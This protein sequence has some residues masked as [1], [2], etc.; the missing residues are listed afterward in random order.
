MTIEYWIRG[1]LSL[2]DTEYHRIE[3]TGIILKSSIKMESLFVLG[4]GGIILYNTLFTSGGQTKPGD[5]VKEGTAPPPPRIN[6]SNPS[7]WTGSPYDITYLPYETF[8]GPGNE[9]RVAYILPGGTRVVHSGY[10]TNSIVR[11]NLTGLKPPLKAGVPPNYGKSDYEYK[12]IV[13]SGK[14]V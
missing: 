12:P 8:Y 3:S 11:T 4:A 2:E 7:L 6:Y 13:G 5:E 10:P 9:P 14:N 1:E